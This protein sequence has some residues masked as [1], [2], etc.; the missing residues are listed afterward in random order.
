MEIRQD[1][2]GNPASLAQKAIGQ[3]QLQDWLANR[4]KAKEAIIL[5]DAC[6]NGALIGGYAS[7]NRL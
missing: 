5:L 7:R 4:I 1:Y 2:D 3:D 6:E